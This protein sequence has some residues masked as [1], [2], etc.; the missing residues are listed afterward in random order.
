MDV[1]VKEL[2][3][4]EQMLLTPSRIIPIIMTLNGHVRIQVIIHNP[5]PIMHRLVYGI[6]AVDSVGRL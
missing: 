2:K 5:F 6:A 3:M 4:D 1:A